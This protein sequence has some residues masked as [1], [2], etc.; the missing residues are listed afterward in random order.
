MKD[1]FIGLCQKAPYVCFEKSQ[2][3]QRLQRHGDM[4]YS[5]SFN[6]PIH[7][8]QIIYGPTIIYQCQYLEA[9]EEYKFLNGSL[10]FVAIVLWHDLKVICNEINDPELEFTLLH[11][12]LDLDVRAI[13]QRHAFDYGQLIVSQG[14]IWYKN[15]KID[16]WKESE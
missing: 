13:I 6:K 5:I 15:Y 2:R 9:G 7:N 3:E 12:L 10:P 16:I 8:L 1:A 4:C 14:G 11:I